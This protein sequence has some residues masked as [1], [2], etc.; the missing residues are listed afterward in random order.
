[1]PTLWT[2]TQKVA[3]PSYNIF[4]T[5]ST[6]FSFFF[7]TVYT[8]RR[9]ILLFWARVTNNRTKSRFFFLWWFRTIFE[10]RIN[11]FESD[12]CE[13][14]SIGRQFAATS[15]SPPFVISSRLSR[16]WQNFSFLPTGIRQRT[17]IYTLPISQIK[18]PVQ[19]SFLRCP[20]LIV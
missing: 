16:A 7:I 4:Y 10:G 13:T 19:Y 17:Y 9:P 11:N 12:G 18:S 6:I 8:K 5:L 1:M 14:D 2:C 20:E 15:I 3:N